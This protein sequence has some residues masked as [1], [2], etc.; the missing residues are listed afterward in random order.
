MVNILKRYNILLS[1][2]ILFI[3]IT[4]ILLI[5]VASVFLIIYRLIFKFKSIHFK[6]MSHGLLIKISMM[7]LTFILI[8]AIL[9]LL[10]ILLLSNSDWRFMMS[11]LPL[12]AKITLFSFVLLLTSLWSYFI[13][14]IITHPNDQYNLLKHVFLFL[15]Y[16]VKL[17]SLRLRLLKTSV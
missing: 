14:N 1:W 9:Y 15:Q 3:I 16:Y 4:I 17:I 13:L 2:N 7:M 6:T 8:L 12:Q 11:W 5:A 10:P